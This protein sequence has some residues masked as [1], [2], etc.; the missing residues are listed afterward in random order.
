MSSTVPSTT[1]AALGA[2]IAS[3][4]QQQACI[5]RQRRTHF[6]TLTQREREVFR[7]VMDGHTNQEIASLL[8]LSRRTV[9]VHRAKVLQ[10]LQIRNLAQMACQYAGVSGA[11]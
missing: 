6:E 4:R 5:E 11:G 8:G 2:A 7:F 10:K 9:E 3:G 1:A